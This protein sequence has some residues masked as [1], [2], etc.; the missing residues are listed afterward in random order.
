M[1]LKGMKKNVSKT[2]LADQAKWITKPLLTLEAVPWV[3]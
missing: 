2:N 3:R 1:F